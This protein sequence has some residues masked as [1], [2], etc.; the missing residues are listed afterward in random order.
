MSLLPSPPELKPDYGINAP[1]LVRFFFLT[2]LSGI[3]TGIILWRMHE[4]LPGVWQIIAWTVLC[5]G[6]PLLLTS[7]AMYW[8]SKTGKLKLC[9][10]I[11][12]KMQLQGN[13][14]VLD[15]GCG[16]GLFLLGIA[17]KLST[18]RAAGIDLWHARDQSG[19]AITA[20]E[21][22]ARRE[23]V[24]EKVELH[25]GDMRELPF[26][27][28]QF[29]VV[30]SIWAIHNIANGTGRLQAIKEIARVLKSGG[31]LV[32]V[33]ISYIRDYQDALKHLGWSE[34]KVIG[35]SYHFVIPSY[36]LWAVKP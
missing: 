8:G 13:E 1:G 2:S 16:R 14:Q 31:K 32:I 10:Q 4:S 15:V 22:N 21:E 29:D 3:F 9:D 34:I 30:I 36:Q 24:A 20:T 35:P 5:S 18:G 27:D 28:A 12:E 6:I 33:D 23:G 11:I 26:V 19:N 25:T 7:L 17:K